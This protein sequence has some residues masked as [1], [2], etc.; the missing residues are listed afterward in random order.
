M[1]VDSTCVR[2]EIECTFLGEA[3]KTMRNLHDALADISAIRGQIARG[4]EFRGYGPAS[5]AACGVLALMVAAIQAHW[6]QYTEHDFTAYLAV[7]V[8]TAAVT[9]ILTGVETV[10]RARRVHTGL[11]V[12]MI[13]NAA[14]QLL[15]SLMAGLLLTMVMMRSAPHAVWMLPGLWEVIFSLG[16]FASCRFL[17]R[18]MFVVGLWYLGAGLTCLGLGTSGSVSAWAMGIPFG[19]GQLLVAVVLQFRYREGW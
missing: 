7:W 6:L 2:H 15:P 14:G 3:T 12:E 10:A 4:T 18:L 9:V 13:Y 1:T 17:P 16:I 11:A 5:V 8:A 19:V